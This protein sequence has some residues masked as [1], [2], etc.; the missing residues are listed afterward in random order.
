[1]ANLDRIFYPTML[2]LLTVAFG[3]WGIG[4]FLQDEIGIVFSLGI[5]INGTWLPTYSTIIY[6]YWFMV[7]YWYIM[8]AGV[9]WISTNKYQ[10]LTA[11]T[12]EGDQYQSSSDGPYSITFGAFFCKHLWFVVV[13]LFQGLHCLE[14][15][16]AY[17][18]LASFSLLGILRIMAFYY[19]W[20]TAVSLRVQDFEKNG[21][22]TVWLEP[23]IRQR[24]NSLKQSIK[25]S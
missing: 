12:V 20:S 18:L 11:A 10:D 25:E 17:G 16:Y 5:Y 19:L 6:A 14:F 2:Y 1:M 15:Y 7:P 4:Y 24:K 21:L 13:V 3:P 22:L 9:T 8:M 23:K